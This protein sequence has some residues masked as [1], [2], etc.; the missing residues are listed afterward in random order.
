MSR[1]APFMESRVGLALILMVVLA[2][3]SQAASPGSAASKPPA[4]A[5]VSTSIPTSSP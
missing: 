1:E 3:C 4:P 2:A 5:I